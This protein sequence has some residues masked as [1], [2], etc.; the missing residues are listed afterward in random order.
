MIDVVV[1]LSG[2]PYCTECL[3]GDEAEAPA[4]DGMQ[5]KDAAVVSP[6]CAIFKAVC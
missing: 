5:M 1:D 3:S 4:F 6:P 2:G